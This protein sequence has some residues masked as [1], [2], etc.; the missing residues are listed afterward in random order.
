MSDHEGVKSRSPHTSIVSSI[1]LPV[2][3]TFLLVYLCRIFAYMDITY[4]PVGGLGLLSVMCGGSGEWLIESFLLL[5][6]SQSSST[7]SSSWSENP[8]SCFS[9]SSLK[10][11]PPSSSSFFL[12]FSFSRSV[13]LHFAL[14]FWNQT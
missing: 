14:R 5:L 7:L 1:L 8:S 9:S 6:S 10:P 11:L 2:T 12:C 13:F 3:G 4:L